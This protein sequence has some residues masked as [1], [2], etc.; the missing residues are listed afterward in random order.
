LAPDWE[1]VQA[2]EVDL[3]LTERARAEI[4]QFFLN[5]T[6]FTDKDARIAGW[7]DAEAAERLV[8]EKAE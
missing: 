3:S 7:L 5:A 2:L 4:E 1:G 6:L 8:R